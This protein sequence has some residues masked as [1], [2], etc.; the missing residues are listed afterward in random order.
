[1]VISILFVEARES[2]FAAWEPCDLAVKRIDRSLGNARQATALMRV[3]NNAS[4][5]PIGNHP[6]YKLTSQ[7]NSTLVT[8]NW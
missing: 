8:R 7:N 4:I 3:S 2:I 6:Q 1:M 5:K